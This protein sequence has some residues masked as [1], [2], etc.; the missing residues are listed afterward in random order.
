MKHL[1]NKFKRNRIIKYY[2]K[3][4]ISIG[5]NLR[6]FDPKNVLIDTQNPKLISIGD[7]VMI[8]RGVIILTHDYSW[9]VL[10]KVYNKM[11]GNIGTVKIGN[12]C[13]IG[14]NSI[15]L[16]NTEIGDNVIIGA[17]SVV[18]GK[19]ESNSVYCGVPARKIMSLDEYNN[20][21]ENNQIKDIKN[22]FSFIKNNS[23]SE[24]SEND[25]FE[26]FYLYKNYEDLSEREKKQIDVINNKEIVIN[27]KK[28]KKYNSFSEL[29]NLLT[30]TKK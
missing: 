17:G 2:K 13:F 11:Y 6:I 27:Y 24:I 14:M 15:V 20:K 9:A 12:N 8:T 23:K 10:S 4:G 25:F 16:K 1:I 7:N 3:I 5:N 19:I 22:V 30:K 28:N 21:I 29:V 26:Y 18:S